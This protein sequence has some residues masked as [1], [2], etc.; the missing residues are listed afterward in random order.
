MKNKNLFGAVSLL[1][2]A[3]LVMGGCTPK[4]P[5]VSSSST[6]TSSSENV[7]KHTVTFVV[8]GET[9]QTLQ[10]VEGEPAIYTGA[11]P[12]KTSSEPGLVYRFRGWDKDISAPITEDT[13]FTAKFGLYKENGYMVDDFESY[14]R[15]DDG[16]R[17]LDEAGWKALHYENGTW[18]A[19]GSKNTISIGSNSEEGQQS[20]RFDSWGNGVGYMFIKDIQKDEYPHAANALKFR[21]MTPSFNQVKVLFLCEAEIEGT[22]QQPKF[23]YVINPTTS[24]YVEYILPFD[25]NGWMLWDDPLKTMA[26]VADWTGIH[27]DDVINY[28]TRLQFF[29]QGND[30]SNG[31]PQISF[32]DSVSFV[33][34]DNP[35]AT[36]KE[37]FKQYKQYTGTTPS[38]N[39]VKLD[40]IDEE[41]MTATVVDLE[42]PEVIEGKGSMDENNIVHFVSNDDGA[43]LNYSGKI[44]NGGQN[45]KFVSA[46]GTKANFIGDLDFDAVH[47]LDNFENYKE[48]G[49]M[50]YQGNTNVNNRSGLRGAYYCEYY[51]GGSSDW[52][53][54]G[55]CLM[56]GKGDQVNLKTDGGHSGNNYGSF[57]HAKSLAMRYLQWGLFDGT[58][59]KNSYHGKYLSFWIKTAG[60]GYIKQIK[61]KA[62]SQTTPRNSSKDN[63]MRELVVNKTG[64]ISEW[65]HFE[66]ELNPALTYYGY[67]FFMEKFEYGST[68]DPA[69]LHIDDVEIYTASPYKTYQA[70]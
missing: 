44:L 23:T 8:E 62:Y 41:N 33:T 2:C 9:I 15:G 70:H 58:S 18:V 16:I 61:F 20:L 28:L 63:C 69:Y 50:Y 48:S 3:L 56:G 54:D 4:T 36:V 40:A 66:L 30:N 13:V 11:A 64:A 24:Q 1:F 34:L 52:G 31:Q 35:K 6:E 57:K 51:G 53:G 42:T 55:W 19:E 5:A 49:T 22:I 10:V 45:I 21:L 17:E 68:E 29:I 43:T 67:Y 37:H 59:E 32:L 39:V 46:S 47:V 7:I 27:Q 12:S 14:H 65:T 60:T 38:G 25:D 26:K